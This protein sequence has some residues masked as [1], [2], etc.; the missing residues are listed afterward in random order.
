MAKKPTPFE[1]PGDPPA[2]PRGRRVRPVVPGKATAATIP[3]TDAADSDIPLKLSPDAVAGT[4]DRELA[5]DWME[6]GLQVRRRDDGV[7]EQVLPGPAPTPRFDPREEFPDWDIDLLERRLLDPVIE[8]SAPVL[9]KDERGL[10]AGEQP[11][12]YKRWVDTHVPSRLQVLTQKGGYRQATWDLLLNK[13]EIGDRDET[14]QDGVVRRGEKGRYVLVYMPY[15]YWQRIKT[16]QAEKRTEKERT[17]MKRIAAERGASDP[18]IGSQ[19]ADQIDSVFRGEI[20]ELPPQKL[21]EFAASG[22]PKDLRHGDA[23][24]LDPD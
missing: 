18:S 3:A 16:A 2:K 20:K 6:Q 4:R 11:K 1:T 9:F 14:A 22:L 12:W 23:T 5:L 19:G 10:R 15:V 8:T 17:N 7:Y 21:K 24:V 13:D